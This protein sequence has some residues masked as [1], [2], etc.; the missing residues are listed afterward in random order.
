MNEIVFM[1]DA[2]LFGVELTAYAA[3]VVAIVIAGVWALCA[4]A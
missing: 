3:C 1:V 4:T 2:F